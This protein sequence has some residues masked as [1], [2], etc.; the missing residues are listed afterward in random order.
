[1]AKDS[2]EIV[3]QALN[4]QEPSRVPLDVGG[5]VCS[6]LHVSCVDGLREHYG[7]KKQ[8]PR[9]HN[10]FMGMGMVEADLAEAM[11]LDCII[12]MPATTDFGLYNKDWKEWRT[13][14]GQDVL[15]PGMF[16]TTADAN[17]DI[18]LYPQG[19]T[20]VPPSGR[21]PKEGFYFDAIVRQP[22]ID[23]DNLDPE[24]NIAD[25]GP[26]TDA[27]L[28]DCKK[29]ADEAATTG[30][31]VIGGIPGTGLGDIAQIPGLHMK[32]PKGIRDIEEWYIST[33]TRR[34]YLDKV[35]AG[36]VEIALKNMRRMKDVLGDAYEAVFVC[37][38]DFGTQ[39]STFCSAESL[40]E[41]QMPHYRKINGWL[42]ENTKWKTMKHSC[43]AV[44]P[45]ISTFIDS[46]FDILNPVQCSAT[47]MD[48]VELKRKYGAKLVFWGGGVDTQKT[49]PFGTAEQVRAEVLERCRAFSP[50]GG[51]IFAAIHN[52]QALTPTK[53]IVA[54]VDAVHEFNRAGR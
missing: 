28:A 1:M 21:M 17:G 49:L 42:H 16:N 3:R 18:L 15:V 6:G 5:T 43:G 8:L 38:S 53:N 36:Q 31:A 25:N 23:D 27:F 41:L 32:H 46:G 10:V 47:G 30:L 34:D 12:A 52:I 45:L 11:G 4:H 24:D 9:M 35:F 20:S 51:F 37:G 22:E 50:G 54:M 19:D 13:P 29:Y 33:V 26:V 39:N 7:L 48:P 2:K 40:R 44:E 14:W